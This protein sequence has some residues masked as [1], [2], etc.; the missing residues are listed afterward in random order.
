LN[1]DLVS[2]AVAREG[3]AFFNQTEET[4]NVQRHDYVS[5]HVVQLV[6]GPDA[7]DKLLRTGLRF[8]NDEFL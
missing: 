1:L 3:R 2:L 4:E 8:P 7:L 5:A 6:G